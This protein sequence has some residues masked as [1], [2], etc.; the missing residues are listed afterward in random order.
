MMVGFALGAF[1]QSFTD[2][3]SLLGASYN[4]GGVVGVVDMDQ[5]GYDDV[6]IFD[7]SRMIYVAYQESDGTFTT[8]NYG[9]ISGAAQWGGTAGDVDNN[10]HNDIFSGGSFD[11][12]H[13]MNIVERGNAS[14]TGLDEGQLFMQGINLVDMNNDGWLDGFGCDDVA[15]SNIWGNDGAGNLIPQ[16]DWID[17]TTTPVS[18]NSGNYGSVW[19]DFDNDGDIDL[20]IAKCRQG[21]NDPLDPRRINALFVN[22]GNGNFTEEAAERGLVIYEQSWTSDFA[23]ID[24]DGDFDCF[25]TNHSGT[26]R[27][28]ENDGQGYFTDIT[29]GSGLDYSG[30]FLQGKLSDFDNDGF[31]DIIFAGGTHRY[32]KNNGDKTFTEIPNMF[33]YS[34]TMHSFG[35]GDLN[36]DGYL[37][38]YASYGD[39]YVSA[40][41]NNPDIM[42]FNEGTD[43]NWI[44]FDLEGTV[45]NINAIGARVEIYGD[46]GVQI[47]EVRAGES[48]GITCSFKTH[49]GIGSSESVDLVVVRFPSGI[50]NVI[51]NPEVNTYHDVLETECEGPAAASIESD[52]LALCEGQSTTLTTDA[53]ENY[54][55]STGSTASSI[56]VDNP[57]QYS[58]TTYADGCGTASEPVAIENIVVEIPEVNVLGELEFCEGGEVTLVAPDS[59]TYEWSNGDEQQAISV[60]EAGSYHVTVDSGTPCGDVSSADIVVE[61]FATPAAPIAADATIPT[62]GEITLTGDSENIY[63]YDAEDAT[64]PIGEGMEFTTNIS[65]TTT[66]YAESYI[67]HGGTVE[68]GGRENNDGPGAYHDNSTY[69]NLFD[70]YEDMIITS[71]KVYSGSAGMRTIEVIDN[72]GNTVTSGMFDIEEG[73]SRVDLNFSVPAGT[74]Y[75]LKTVGNP[76]LWRNS[77]GTDLSY[78]Y[79][80]GDLAAITG[81]NITGDNEL[82]YYYFFY[83]WEVTQESFICA[84]DRVPVLATVVGVEEIDALSSLNI[85]PNPVRSD[86]NLNIVLDRTARLSVDIMDATGRVVKNQDFGTNGAGSL[87]MIIGVSDLAS[88][89]Y[90]MKLNVDKQFITQRIIV[91]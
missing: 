63:W 16:N 21:V 49:F 13:Y 18:D 48:Y 2:Q 12:T 61:V 8:E 75:A 38:V 69:Y 72:L 58:I 68:F 56:D 28:L 11:G 41:N 57:G 43:N 40:D 37:D 29:E 70:A 15:E 47:R 5:D 1:S 20:F 22:D 55:W 6:L 78:P 19:C 10:G 91:E 39:G 86:L 89:V 53:T 77:V 24:N 81:T 54:I 80:I 30:F 44:G 60:S 3:T 9:S 65:E 27:M 36:N 4:S 50:I 82:N 25:L 51:E 26:L 79:E 85:Y 46:W 87:N 84:S 64:L 7:N 52:Q 73:E 42:W 66:F 17:M 90:M 71:V 31:V 62:P 45:S 35:I 88:G 23:D 59:D 33:P 34:D 74:G 14:L 83:D 67:D 76:N 32:L